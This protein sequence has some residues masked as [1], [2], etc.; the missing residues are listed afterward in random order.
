MAQLAEQHEGRQHEGDSH[1]PH[2]DDIERH[3]R[4]QQ[5]KSR[6]QDAVNQDVR[7]T[8]TCQSYRINIT[9]L[10]V[11]LTIAQLIEKLAVERD[12]NDKRAGQHPAPAARLE[13]EIGAQELQGRQQKH[14]RNQIGPRNGLQTHRAPRIQEAEEEAQCAEHKRPPTGDGIERGRPQ[15]HQETGDIGGA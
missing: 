10:T 7:K 6:H 5:R 14:M 9:G 2:R 11:A 12:S 15:R 8:L 13:G 3:A 1:D 4:H